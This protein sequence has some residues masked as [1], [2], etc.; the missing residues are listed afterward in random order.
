MWGSWGRIR[1]AAVLKILNHKTKLTLNGSLTYYAP[2][3]TE[4]ENS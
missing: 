2:S 1:L 3:R 4:R